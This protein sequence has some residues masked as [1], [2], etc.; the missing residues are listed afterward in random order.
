MDIPTDLGMAHGLLG[1]TNLDNNMDIPEITKENEVESYAAAMRRTV[2]KENTYKHL[3]P[4]SLFVRGP[5]EIDF[6][7][8]YEELTES[9]TTKQYTDYIEALYEIRKMIWIVTFLQSEEGANIRDKIHVIRNCR[10]T[11]IYN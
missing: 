11:N 3:R 7:D 1:Y 8:I 4:R 6:E 2:P 10:N 5:E 9:S